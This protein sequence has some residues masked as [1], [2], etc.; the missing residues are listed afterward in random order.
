MCFGGSKSSGAT[1]APA[2]PTTFAPVP[3]DT[4]NQQ[5]RKAAVLSSTD[6]PAALG[7]DLGSGGTTPSTSMGGM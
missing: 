6:K 7:S 3:A 1:P 2:P 5:Q 4:S